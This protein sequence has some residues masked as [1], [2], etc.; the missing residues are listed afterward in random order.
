MHEDLMVFLPDIIKTVWLE[1]PLPYDERVYKKP[2][3]DEKVAYFEICKKRWIEYCKLAG[4]DYR[5][6][7][8]TS[9]TMA[10][11]RLMCMDKL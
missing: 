2:T 11:N 8:S 7:D 5:P 9:V 1:Y 10:F 3:D 4:P 6:T